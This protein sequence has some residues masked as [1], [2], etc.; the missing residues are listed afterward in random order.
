[1]R[2]RLKEEARATI[3]ARPTEGARANMKTR[4]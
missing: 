2:A 3:K 1:M 4:H